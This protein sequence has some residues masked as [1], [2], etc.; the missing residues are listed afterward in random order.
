MDS[1]RQSDDQ[2]LCTTEE[3][4]TIN[5]GRGRGI[6]SGDVINI[7]HFALQSCHVCNVHCECTMFWL[8]GWNGTNSREFHV[9]L[10]KCTTRAGQSRLP[11]SSTALGQPQPPKCQMRR[12]S[13]QPPV[14]QIPSRKETLH[15]RFRLGIYV[16]ILHFELHEPVAPVC[17]PRSAIAREHVEYLRNFGYLSS[18]VAL[19]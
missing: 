9:Y 11:S 16:G 8:F 2:E 19:T 6:P 1:F 7:L 3:A 12:S 4:Y 17:F 15:A 18:V 14:S 13:L 10:G 5:R